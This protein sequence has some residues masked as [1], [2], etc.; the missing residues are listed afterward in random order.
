MRWENKAD[1]LF[2]AWSSSFRVEH[3]TGDSGLGESRDHRVE[4]NR[5]CYP[6]MDH[7]FNLQHCAAASNCHLMQLVK[8]MW[9]N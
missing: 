4:A 5:H 9:G 8:L 7:D 3:R 2:S 1:E 6:G